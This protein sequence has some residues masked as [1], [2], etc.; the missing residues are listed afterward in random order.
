[1]CSGVYANIFVKFRQF[2]NNKNR[3]RAPDGIGHLIMLI[4]YRQFIDL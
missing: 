2:F 3:D 4:A 1:M